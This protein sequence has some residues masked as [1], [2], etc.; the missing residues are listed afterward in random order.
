MPKTMKKSSKYMLTGSVD[1]A[2]DHA[3]KKKFDRIWVI[4]G[5][6]IYDSAL[7]T[8]RVDKIYI[9]NIQRMCRRSSRYKEHTNL[10]LMFVFGDIFIWSYHAACAGNGQVAGSTSEQIIAS[11]HSNVR[12]KLRLCSQ[13]LLMTTRA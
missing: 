1:E 4:G 5:A 3:L 9:T 8:G 12:P 7:R 10:F 2:I 13:M 6:G 11:A